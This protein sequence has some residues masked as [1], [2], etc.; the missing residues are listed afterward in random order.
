VIHVLPLEVKELGYVFWCHHG[1]NNLGFQG[2]LFH[3]SI[4]NSFIMLLA[5]K[6]GIPIIGGLHL[7]T[8]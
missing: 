6:N 1:L 7:N 5:I 3:V 4:S 8:E 2:K